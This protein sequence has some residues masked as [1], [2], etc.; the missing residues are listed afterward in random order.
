MAQF[1]VGFRAGANITKIEGKSFKDE[2]KYG[3]L[4]GGFAEIGVSRKFSINPEVLFNQYTGTVSDDYKDIYEGVFNS[5][6]SKVKINYL[7]IPL[8]LD[9]KLLGP[10]HLQAGPQFSVLMNKDKNFLENGGDAFT[11]GDLALL[12]G[13]QLKLSAL[14]IT[15]R[16]VVGLNNI[17]DI[18]NQDKWRSQAFQ[19]TAGF[20]L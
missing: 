14:R 3:Y 5:D 8:V 1:H 15:G 9:Y 11:K 13:V 18:D 12:G 20:A 6:Q 7:S 19:L 16:Y 4:L 17:N 2:F 10:I